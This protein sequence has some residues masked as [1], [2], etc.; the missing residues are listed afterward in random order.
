MVG[1]TGH[2]L[3]SNTQPQEIGGLSKIG[4]SICFASMLAAIQFGIAG[5]YLASSLD[6][7][8]RLI[9]ASSL[10]F[11]GACVVLI[12]DRNFIYAADTSIQSKGHLTYVYLAI[13]IFLILVISSLSSQFT[14]PLLLKSELEIHVQDLRD[15][16]YDT[17]KDRYNNKYDLP[18]KIQNERELSKQITQLKSSLT[19]LPQGLVHQKLATEQCFREYKKKSNAAIGPDVDD[20]EVANL[21]AREKIQCEQ[22]ELAYKEAYKLY[23][24]PRQAEL[25]LKN[26][27]YKHVVSDAAQAQSSFK[28]DLQRAEENNNHFL[29]ASSSDVLWSLIRNNPGARTKYLMLTLAQLVLELMPLLL[30]SLL[31]RSPLGTRI[32]MQNQALA[33]ELDASSHESQLDK[34]ARIGQLQRSQSDIDIESLHSQI[35][36]QKLKNEISHLKDEARTSRFSFGFVGPRAQNRA[37]SEQK[38]RHHTAAEKEDGEPTSGFYAIQ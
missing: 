18:E 12:I 33:D 36:M 10:G 2:H 11:I 34:L 31:G 4:L 29:N 1:I 19:N 3:D 37:H 27:T 20:E 21:Y 15:E 30:K 17:A 32:A 25:A 23:I 14:L 38:P 6:P 35:S 24:T 13:R 8:S 7:D 16:R 28:G 26:E 9:L 22:M 5:W